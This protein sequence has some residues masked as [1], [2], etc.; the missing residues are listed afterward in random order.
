MKLS[1]LVK[2]QF[3][4]MSEN[5]D[6]LAWSPTDMPGLDPFVI[7]HKL[8]TLPEKMNAEWVL[9]LTAYSWVL[10]LTANDYSFS[11]SL[12]KDGGSPNGL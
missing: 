9:A 10:A 5:L 7:C 3:K 11:G 6:V 1:D 12:L 4:F 8:S 2:D